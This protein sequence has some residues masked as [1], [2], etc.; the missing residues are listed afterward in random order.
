MQKT[1][2][3]ENLDCANCA[4]ELENALRGIAGINNVSI[5][6]M[7]QKLVIDFAEDEALVMKE[8]RRLAAKIEPDCEISE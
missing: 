3:I 4:A 8:V 1:Y 7:T 6:F 5:S 2:H